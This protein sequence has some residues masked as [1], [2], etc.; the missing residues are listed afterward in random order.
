MLEQI[1]D[2][3]AEV[4]TAPPELTALP[5]PEIIPSRVGQLTAEA[6][7]KEFDSAAQAIEQMANELLAIKARMD[8]EQAMILQAIDEINAT[9]ARYR[10]EGS[11]I[12]ASVED[13]AKQTQRVRDICADLSIKS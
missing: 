8:K 9:A 10:Q 13:A 1:A 5:A 12:S 6:M 4:Q 11:R 3:I 7:K 2:D